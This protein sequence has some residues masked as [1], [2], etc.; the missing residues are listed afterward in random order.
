[1]AI[2]VVNFQPS[3]A[4]FDLTGALMKAM[5]ARYQGAL[6]N[7]ENTLLPEEL[8]K[9][10]LENKW[11]G[12]KMSADIGLEGAQ[13]GLAGAQI[14]YYQQETLNNQYKREHGLLEPEFIQM[15]RYFQ[16]PEFKKLSSGQSQ[17]S[18]DIAGQVA[19]TMLNQSNNQQIPYSQYSNNMTL[20]P[21]AEQAQQQAISLKNALAPLVAQQV[22]PPQPSGVSSAMDQQATESQ[23]GRQNQ[24]FN[25]L[26]STG[27]PVIDAYISNKLGVTGNEMYQQK[28]AQAFNWVHS[29]QTMKDYEVAQLAG[30]GIDPSEA[31]QQLGEGSTVPEILQK[32][33][34]DPSNPP[35]PDFLPT[36]GNVTVLKNRQAA[37]KEVDALTDFVSTGLGPYSQRVWNMSPSQISDAITGMNKDKQIDFLAARILAPELANARLMMANG[38]TG[39]TAVNQIMDKS[40][41]NAKALQGLVRPEVFEKAQSKATEVLKDAFGKATKAYTV[42]KNQKQ[43]EKSG[44][45]ET[46][47]SDPLGLR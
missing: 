35:E 18:S 34:F 28:A 17:G 13:A 4:P 6:A 43:E 21:A 3:A 11:Y 24:T 2:P 47:K 32:H 19:N 22:A 40:M 5:Q 36:K 9:A 42:G 14:P 30:A 31:V 16:S 8:R 46:G 41:T 26:P 33:G 27:N 25:G 10:Q 37:L 20:T 38:R 1:M 39:I 12:P 29:T 15:M 45:S 23:Q 7:K 44:K